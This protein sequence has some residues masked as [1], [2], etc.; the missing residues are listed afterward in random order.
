MHRK[1]AMGGV[2]IANMTSARIHVR[3]TADS[4]QGGIAFYEIAPQQCDNWGR[5]HMQVAFVRRE[6][7]QKTEVLAVTPGLCYVI[8]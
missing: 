4:E 2:T 5:Q 6:D 8:S 3:I 1:M 7:N